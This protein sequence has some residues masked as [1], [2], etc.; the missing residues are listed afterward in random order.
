MPEYPDEN[1]AVSAGKRIK[2][3]FP[4]FLTHNGENC[5]AL[6]TEICKITEIDKFFKKVNIIADRAEQLAAAAREQT[7]KRGHPF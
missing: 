6:C 5:R 4:A 7:F 3:R 1:S 2:V